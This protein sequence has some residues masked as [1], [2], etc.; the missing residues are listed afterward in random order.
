MASKEV[1]LAQVNV[2]VTAVD[3]LFATK[4]LLER[5]Q[6]YKRTEG[7]TDQYLANIEYFDD[8]RQHFDATL[9]ARQQAIERQKALGRPDRKARKKARR[10]ATLTSEPTAVAA[11]PRD[12]EASQVPSDRASLLSQASVRAPFAFDDAE[13]WDLDTWCS[14]NV[15]MWRN[16]SSVA[17]VLN[18]GSGDAD[19]D[20]SSSI[21]ILGEWSFSTEFYVR[22]E[23]IQALIEI[24][25]HCLQTPDPL[26][27]RI[28]P[29]LKKLVLQARR[30]SGRLR[31]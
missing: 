13:L 18:T 10:A 9:L 4:R 24:K 17:R 14:S 30:G 23:E 3:L 29:P 19:V 15:G 20:T 5:L 25:R 27:S 1:F 7:W 26:G 22:M 8:L 12:Q 31:C 6:A 28:L 2:K 16:T 11:A 21:N